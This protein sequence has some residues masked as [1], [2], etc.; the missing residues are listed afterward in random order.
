MQSIPSRFG[1]A[2]RFAPKPVYRRIG[3]AVVALLLFG[4]VA[5]PALASPGFVTLPDGAVV[6]VT[7]PEGAPRGLVLVL[8]DALGGDPR[9][10]PYVDRLL[11][12]GFAALEPQWQ[13]VPAASQ[14]ALGRHLAAILPD[15]AG[16]FGAPP[17]AVGIVGFGLGARIALQAALPRGW[18]AALLYPGCAGLLADSPVAAEDE[19]RGW[20]V[21]LQASPAAPRLLLL[22][23]SA[24][25]AEP[26]GACDGLAAR[27]GPVAARHVYY[28]ATYGWDYAPG[29]WEN[30]ASLLPSPDGNGPLRRAHMSTGV[31]ADA[32][33][34]VADFMARTVA[35]PSGLHP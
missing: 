15:T 7:L 14:P 34:R 12:A 32:A 35:A 29:P 19:D 2:G 10:A 25:S 28:G 17:E 21:A 20:R 33:A 27:L 6:R 13:R 26:E 11:A 31:T 3:P 1:A 9:S 30:M 18:P 4:L 24:D 22:H 5:A 8:P 23:G 16:Q